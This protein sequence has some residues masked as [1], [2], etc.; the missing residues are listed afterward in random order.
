MH[1][2]RALLNASLAGWLVL[3]ACRA[4][5]PSVNV[6]VNVPDDAFERALVTRA[7]GSS[8]APVTVYELS[9]FQCPY[10]RRFAMETYPAIDSL[11]VRTG[12]VRWV[13]ITYPRRLQVFKNA[14]RA[15]EFA[16]CAGGAGRFWAYH[17]KLFA[18]QPQWAPLDEPD[19]YFMGLADSVRI[20]RQSIS[21]CLR[22]G[23]AAETV[24]AEKSYSEDLGIG[25]VPAFVVDRVMIAQGAQPLATFVSAIDSV[26]A[27]RGHCPHGRSGSG[28]ACST[29]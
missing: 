29:R 9:D 17:D 26:L 27:K 5:T 22:N 8:A 20:D 16:V 18:T 23:H 7:R 1:T 24:D 28:N 21:N 14:H 15:A 13:F 11:Y 6:S 3:G 10:C 19:E 2:M 4:P 25:G 12:L